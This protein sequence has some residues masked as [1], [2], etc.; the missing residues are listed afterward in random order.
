MFYVRRGVM[1]FPA[2]CYLDNDH[3]SNTK[4]TIVVMYVHLC[5]VSLININFF[6]VKMYIEFLGTS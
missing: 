6:F 3:K 5:K 1:T 2:G 4:T